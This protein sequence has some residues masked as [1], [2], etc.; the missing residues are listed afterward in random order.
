MATS[1]RNPQPVVINSRA[2]EVPGGDEEATSSLKLGEFENVP[3]LSHS[4][5]KY[6]IDVLKD[7]RQ[8]SNNRLQ[9]TE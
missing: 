2:R 4:E 7:R 1:A 5:A 9:E 3:T 8:A 6:L